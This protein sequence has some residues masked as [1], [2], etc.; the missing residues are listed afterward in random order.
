MIGPRGCSYRGRADPRQARRPR[1]ARRAAR[2]GGQRARGRDLPLEPRGDLGGRAV[3]L[4]GLR[5]EP[6]SERRPVGRPHPDPRPRLGDR[7]VGAV[8]QRLVPP[9]RRTRLRRGPRRG[10]RVLPPVPAHPCRGRPR[11]R[12]ALRRRRDRRLAGRGARRLRPPL[13]ADRNSPRRG[14]RPPRGSLPR[15]LPDGTLPRRRLLRVAVPRARD[16]RVPARRAR[17]LGRR[18]PGR[19]A[20]PCSRASPASR[21]SRR[22]W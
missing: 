11:L 16:R 12:R 10:R 19:P 6:A 7:R 20:W 3:R 4:A 14:R 21:C 18:R 8:G 2:V 13:P 17:S 9:H 15:R 22:S 1:T 5:A